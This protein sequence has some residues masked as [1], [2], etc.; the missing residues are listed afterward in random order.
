VLVVWWIG[1]G[2]VLLALVVLALSVLSVLGSLRRL[3]LVLHTL[4]RRV[5]DGSARLQPAVL[6][7]QQRATEL[8]EPLQAAQERAAL[9]QARRGETS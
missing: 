4:Q 9:I 7:L 2:V 3:A 8:E 6:A 1:G 5:T